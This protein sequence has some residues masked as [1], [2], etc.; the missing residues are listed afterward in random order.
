MRNIGIIAHID[1]GKT[2]T[3]E[4]MLYY[5]GLTSR[6]GNVD[7]G[8]TVTD[9]LPAER[10]R[11]ITIQS[12]AITF[13]WNKATVN[14]IDTPGHADFGFEVVRSLRIL[15]GAI[16][17]LDAVAG[18]EAQTEK[19]WAQASDLNIPKIV[20]INKMDR[21]GAG[22]SRTVREVVSKLRTP[23]ALV[24]IPYF[25][26]HEFKGVIDVFSKSVIQWSGDGK[27]VEVSPA[28]EIGP[29]VAK[30]AQAA[31][32]ALV[33]SLSID[34]EVVDAFLEAEEDFDAVSSD[35]LKRA[36]ARLTQSN[37]IVPVL[38]G[39]SFRNIGVQPLLD[40]VVE[41][42][43]PP[44]IETA[45]QNTM[46]AL[47]FKV[48]YDPI[49]GPLVYVRVYTGTL[50]RGSTVLN[51]TTQTKEKTTKLLQM[52][53]DQPIDIA[54]IPA[55]SI[56]VLVGTKDIKTGDTLIA[57]P[58]KKDGIS[59]LPQDIKKTKLMPIE[60]PEPVFVSRITPV[61][62]A[63]IRS[64]KAALDIL[65]REDPSL[66]LS[67]DDETG[68]WLLAGMGELHLE[69][70]RDR[71]VQDLKANV[72]VGEI[73]ITLKETL[74]GS[75]NGSAKRESDNGSVSAVVKI[76]P[77]VEQEGYEL[78]DSNIYNV[79]HPRH[80]VLSND[81]IAAAVGVGITPVLASGGKVGR[82]AL[83]KL[84]FS[85]K[86]DL[87]PE[88]QSTDAISAAVREASLEALAST[89]LE[90][91]TLLE[92]VMK[93]AIT[94]PKTEMG[95]VM[96]DL[97]SNRRGHILGLGDE[98]TASD[99]KFQ[100]MASSMYAPTD[101]TMYLSKHEEQQAQPA[102]LHAHVPLRKMVGYLTSLR[103]MTQG[104]G[105]IQMTFASFEPVESRDIDQV[106]TH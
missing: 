44:K 14:L 69:I 38:C 70:A 30:E 20:Y 86:L 9:F 104:R 56:G 27:H 82:R 106:L 10:E 68:Q 71:L 24:N 89:P 65:L 58:T 95:T 5:A 61:S 28:S 7:A 16:T 8:D 25:R 98:S 81:E 105:T 42:L 4:R 100:Q 1:A 11:G 77:L 57:H 17:V 37:Q 79:R 33:D 18:V 32:D 64:M 76:E 48:R 49:R 92:P 60:I 35:L 102:V 13:G 91:F 88:L 66:N 78:T 67:Y 46:Q 51:T 43:P 73:M 59:T 45:P 80:P 87:A 75:A 15:D 23:V 63:D 19:V 6:L 90:Q 96:T 47:A 29:D 2:T 72:E 41:Y 3:T 97:S 40:S 85:V 22:F 93:V 52:Q 31:R 34:E 21:A 103:S 12:A 26:D 83:Y 84:N 39:S 55:G 101:H 99:D 74:A 53:A 62:V 50:K 54:E 94:V 36:L